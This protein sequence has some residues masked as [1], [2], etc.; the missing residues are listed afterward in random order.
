MKKLIDTLWNGRH[1]EAVRYLVVGGMTTLVSIVSFQLLCFVFGVDPEAP[2]SVY[3]TVSNVISI[4][5]AIL[6]AYA[7][8]KRCVFRSRCE[9]RTALLAEF[10]KFVGARLFT[11]ALEVF[12]VYFFVNLL[13]QYPLL[14]K[15]E[16]QILVVIGNYLISKFLVFRRK[17][18]K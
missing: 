12:G 18:D 15:V 10:G 7:M 16:T 1:G 6:F 14:G 8:N 4:I 9:S 3:V 17:K 11:M 13:G 5:L 2:D